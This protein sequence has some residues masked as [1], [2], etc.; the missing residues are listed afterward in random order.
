[1]IEVNRES[2]AE[3]AV[4]DERREVCFS[5]NQ[6]RNGWGKGRPNRVR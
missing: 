6:P 5:V 1:M 4:W 2:V 3:A